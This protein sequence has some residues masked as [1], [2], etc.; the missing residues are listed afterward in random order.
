MSCPVYGRV[1]L[2]L[3]V[4]HVWNA[5]SHTDN[6]AVEPVCCRLS[7]AVLSR[8]YAYVCSG[9]GK[10]WW[11]MQERAAGGLAM[12]KRK[13]ANKMGSLER[14]NG[15]KPKLGDMGKGMAING[16]EETT[17]AHSFP[18]AAV[19]LSCIHFFITTCSTKLWGV[20]LG[21]FALIPSRSAADR[22][23]DTVRRGLCWPK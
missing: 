17:T 13:R 6:G 15:P 7:W 22:A 3:G 8:A 1:S 19:D 12:V 21:C 5:H 16:C 2:G 9:H 10:R 23:I 14:F 18:R 20:F 4:V 11:L